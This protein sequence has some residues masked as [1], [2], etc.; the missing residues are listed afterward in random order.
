MRHT[1]TKTAPAMKVELGRSFSDDVVPAP[2]DAGD[3]IRRVFP[4]GPP[5]R[6]PRRSPAF[7]PP[8]CR[9]KFK[10]KGSCEIEEKALPS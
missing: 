1:K 8:G 7:P 3:D 2:P 6:A 5:R 9:N 4:P 10:F